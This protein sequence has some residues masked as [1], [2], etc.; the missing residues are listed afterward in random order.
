MSMLIVDGLIVLALWSGA[1]QD[2]PKAEP[3]AA[4]PETG[5]PAGKKPKGEAVDEKVAYPIV[6][7]ISPDPSIDGAALV[8]Q[9]LDAMGSPHAAESKTIGYKRR[10]RL[11]RQNKVTLNVRTEVAIA[12][13]LPIAGRVDEIG[14]DEHGRPQDSAVICNGDDRFVLVAHTV[15]C[16][17]A[18]ERE[19]L[20]TVSRELIASLGLSALMQAGGKVEYLGRSQLETFEPKS[21]DE[22]KGST[23]YQPAKHEYLRLRCSAP[24][25]FAEVSGGT[26]DFWIDPET[27]RVARYSCKDPARVLSGDYTF[28]F[29]IDGYQEVGGLVLPARLHV[30]LRDDAERWETIDISEPKTGVSMALK[31]P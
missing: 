13:T 8:K 4:G 20:L 21:F 14:R 30:S 23:D 10:S 3:P 22:T 6:E 18:R 19:A 31:R 9:V 25:P 15:H 29:T 5:A 1:V 26:V 12:T 28:L 24:E 7:T 2:D 11:W 27:K 16:T 17:E